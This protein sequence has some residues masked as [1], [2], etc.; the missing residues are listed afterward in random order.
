MGGVGAPYIDGVAAVDVGRREGGVPRLC[1]DPVPWNAVPELHDAG[2]A[3]GD[4]AHSVAV[5]EVA[6]GQD[7]GGLAETSA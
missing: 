2:H 7:G 1:R 4:T 3:E 5:A 6:V